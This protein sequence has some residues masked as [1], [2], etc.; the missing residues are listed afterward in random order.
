MET[1]WLKLMKKLEPSLEMILDLI[2]LRV[3]HNWVEGRLSVRQVPI[4]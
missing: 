3:V 2:Y 4:E 1:S